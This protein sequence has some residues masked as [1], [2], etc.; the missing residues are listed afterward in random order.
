MGTGS[1]VR[2]WGKRDGPRPHVNAQ[3]AAHDHVG[4]LLPYLDLYR[5]KG[6]GLGVRVSGFSGF[7]VFSLRCTVYG[8][9]VYG[10]V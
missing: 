1:E 7:A 5:V 10:S 9:R 4:R 8:V 6:L 2:M 3:T